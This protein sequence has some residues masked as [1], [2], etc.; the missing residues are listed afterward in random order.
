MQL[1]AIAICW[2][3]GGGDGITLPDKG[4][5]DHALPVTQK[6]KALTQRGGNVACV[7]KLAYAA[8]HT[9]QQQTVALAAQAKADVT[10]YCI[11][12]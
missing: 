7:L 5:P 8:V 1:Y 12:R 6:R 3:D 4:H 11:K 9:A 2:C 10:L